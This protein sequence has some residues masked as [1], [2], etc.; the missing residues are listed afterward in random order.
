MDPK[1][2]NNSVGKLRLESRLEDG[3]ESDVAEEFTSK[4]FYDSL[5]YLVAW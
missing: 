2:G 3:P 5:L 4:T 1:L